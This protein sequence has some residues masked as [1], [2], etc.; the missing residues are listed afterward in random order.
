[1]PAT[2][3]ATPTATTHRAQVD[4]VAIS[5]D[6]QAGTEGQPTIGLGLT[7][8]LSVWPDGSPV[9]AEVALLPCEAELLGHR[10]LALAETA[11]GVR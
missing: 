4:D 3:T 5:T 11:R 1:M 8:L 2:I 10:L 9:E 7:N 6:I